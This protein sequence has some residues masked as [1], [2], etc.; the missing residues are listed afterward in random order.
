MKD[1]LED[2]PTFEEFERLYDLVTIQRVF[3]AIGSF[4]YIFEHR[5]DERY[6]KYIGFGMEKIKKILLKKSEFSDLRKI[7]FGSYYAS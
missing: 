5:K 1:S 3:K 4:S 6:V 7:L 2:Q